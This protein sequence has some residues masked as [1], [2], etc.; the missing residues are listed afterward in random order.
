MITLIKW[1]LFLL[2]VWIALGAL[3]NH[4]GYAESVEN[5]MKFVAE[6]FYAFFNWAIAAIISIK[7]W[8]DGQ[9][10]SYVQAIDDDDFEPLTD[11]LKKPGFFSYLL[12]DSSVF[13]SNTL[14]VV[15]R[16]K[17]GNGE[18]DE[19]LIEAIFKRFLRHYNNYPAN[20]SVAVYCYMD[21]KK[22]VLL[23]ALS[24][25]GRE[26]IQKQRNNRR[27]RQI[28]SDDDLTE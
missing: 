14:K 4:L 16:Y 25:K 7:N 26:E 22:M 28:P 13:D 8:F 5:G 20:Q 27:S 11:E 9:E 2:A 21:K 17:P 19:A 10:P 23:H 15:Y 18:V 12:L 3:M 24:I 6:K 1:L